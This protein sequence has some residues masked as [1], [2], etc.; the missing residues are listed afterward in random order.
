MQVQGRKRL[1]R[2]LEQEKRG[3]EPCTYGQKRRQSI[4]G[5]Q[6]YIPSNSFQC[7]GVQPCMHK[8]RKHILFPTERDY[9]LKVLI[10]KLF[11]KGAWGLG[12]EGN[13]HFPRFYR[14]NLSA[15]RKE[16]T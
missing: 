16:W 14:D 9:C 7:H 6:D 10:F 12:C 4:L 2:Y 15:R 13:L 11:L 8:S 1:P 3:W 5:S